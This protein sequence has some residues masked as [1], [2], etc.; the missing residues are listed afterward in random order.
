MFIA[1]PLFSLSGVINRPRVSDANEPPPAGEAM[2][3]VERRAFLAGWRSGFD[4]GQNATMRLPKDDEAAHAWLAW[5]EPATL[6]AKADRR[7]QA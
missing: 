1:L 7:R 6:R 5:K 2:S 4:R 3:E